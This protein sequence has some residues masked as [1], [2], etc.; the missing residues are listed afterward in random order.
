MNLPRYLALPTKVAYRFQK[1][2]PTTVGAT[3]LLAKSQKAKEYPQL[4]PNVRAS[5]RVCANSNL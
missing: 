4:I 3:A 2:R 5:I 1:A